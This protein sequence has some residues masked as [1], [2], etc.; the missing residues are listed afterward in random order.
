MRALPLG[1]KFP[2]TNTNLNLNSPPPLSTFPCTEM[3]KN[4]SSCALQHAAN[5]SAVSGALPSVQATHSAH[6]RGK[7][8]NYSLSDVILVTCI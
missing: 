8:Q 2:L 4:A 1:L 6:Q 5:V 7:R 3:K